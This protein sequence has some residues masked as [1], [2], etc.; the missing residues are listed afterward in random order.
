MSKKKKKKIPQAETAD[1]HLCYEQSVQCAE[2]EIDFVT[3]TFK[4]LRNREVRELREDFC[5][6]ATVC[7]DFVA[8]HADNRA[9]GVDLDTDVLNWGREHR[10]NALTSEQALRVSLIEDNV[11]TAKTPKVDA[12]LAMNFSYWL[13]KEREDLVN[14]FKIARE[15][16]KDDGIMF[17]DAFGGYESFQ[18]LEEE[19]EIDDDDAGFAYVW[20]QA[21]FNPINNNMICHISFHFNDGSVMKNAFTYDW[22]MYTLPEIR[23]ILKDAGFQ[24]STIY[25]EGWDEDEEEGN[26]VYEPAEQG[27]ADPGW[28]VYITAEK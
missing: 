11:L 17:L 13:F 9:Y 27:E 24:K 19:R 3:T 8:R 6:T 4:A 21:S 14:Y 23:D 12:L 10:V 7:C 25:W 2:A 1:R 22:R 28:V 15:S 20:D 16:L 26:G 18:E 5:G